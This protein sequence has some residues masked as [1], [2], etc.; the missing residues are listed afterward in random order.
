M[1]TLVSMGIK[2]HRW[3]WLDAPPLLNRLGLLAAPHLIASLNPTPTSL[4]IWH[5]LPAAIVTSRLTSRVMVHCG[6]RQI[7]SEAEAF[8]SP[9]E[10]LNPSLLL[11]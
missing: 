5:F 3:I 7:P 6:G 10:K 8:S 2:S 1:A 9:E 11:T 4:A